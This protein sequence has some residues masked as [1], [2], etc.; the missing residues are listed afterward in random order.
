MLRKYSKLIYSLILPAWVVAGFFISLA[1][2]KGILWIMDKLSIEILSINSAVLESSLAAIIYV[3]ALA[4]VIGLPW[5]IR[6][7]RTSLQEIGLNR[8]PTWT[9]ILI[10]P[11]GF[12]VYFILSAILMLVAAKL[13]PGFN[14]SEAQD[15]GFRQLNHRYEYLLAFAT[16]VVVAPFAEEILFRG[17]MFGKLKKHI[18]VWVAI[19]ISS[20]VFGA[21]HGAWNI[22]IDTFA[23]G[24]ILCLL[25][26]T[27]GS[28]WP[29]ILLHMLK[30]SLAFYILFINPSIFDTLVK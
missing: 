17:F 26:I 3:G 12:I 18:P 11:A 5:L 7:R 21:L 24:V 19:L 14:I 29:S 10:T 16:L 27:T 4:I 15:V 28:I 1:I 30:N 9:E 22:A 20:A 2:V 8:L 25:R 6:R 13:I 23:L